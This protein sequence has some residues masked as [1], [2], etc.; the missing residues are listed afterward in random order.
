MA[1]IYLDHLDKQWK[2]SGLQNRGGENA[3]L[4]RYADDYL[5]IMSGNPAVG[6]KELDGIME[7]MNLTMNTEKTRIVKAEDGKE[8]QDGSHRRDRIGK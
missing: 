5:I 3:H 1:K 4:I 6:K 8:Q 2:A 7:S